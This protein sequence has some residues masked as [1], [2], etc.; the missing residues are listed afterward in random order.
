MWLCGC[1]K[2]TDSPNSSVETLNAPH[3]AQEHGS[4]THTQCTHCSSCTSWHLQDCGVVIVAP[5]QSNPGG[6]QAAVTKKTKDTTLSFAPRQ[7]LQKPS[8]R[9]LEHFQI[10]QLHNP[11]THSHVPTLRQMYIFCCT[12]GERQCRRHERGRTKH[13]GGSNTCFGE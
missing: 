5:P 1:R 3:P 11:V 4:T 10:Q 7:P 9:V 8:A 12:A 6:P 2:M 13:V